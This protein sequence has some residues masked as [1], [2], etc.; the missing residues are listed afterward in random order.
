MR[1]GGELPR[2]AAP[3]PHPGHRRWRRGAGCRGLHQRAVEG[4][5]TG[6]ILPALRDDLSNRSDG[7]RPDW[8]AGCADARLAGHVSDWRRSGSRGCGAPAAA[9]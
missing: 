5:R 1:A 8:C 9:P 7:D 4:P 2:A 6:S 3:P